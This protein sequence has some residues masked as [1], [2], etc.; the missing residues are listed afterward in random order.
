MNGN[1]PVQFLGEGVTVTSP[2]YP[3]PGWETALGYPTVPTARS[4]A[5]YELAHNALGDGPVDPATIMVPSNKPMARTN[6]C[7]V[8]SVGNDGTLMESVILPLPQWLAACFAVSRRWMNR[9]ACSAGSDALKMSLITATESAPA[10]MTPAAFSKRIPPMATMGFFV[11]GL[12]SRRS[13]VPTTGS[14]LALLVVAKIG[15][16][17][18]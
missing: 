16:M 3:T 9:R 12:S 17:A 7:S 6:P 5:A 2:P 8:F 10:S 15:P 1:I 4:D 13:A 11:S 18:T 14:G